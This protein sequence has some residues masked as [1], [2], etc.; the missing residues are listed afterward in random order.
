MFRSVL[1]DDEVHSV[2]GL[3]GDLVAYR[4]AGAGH[5]EFLAGNGF[6]CLR[7]VNC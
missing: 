1:E 6:S 3:L 7:H 4:A 5:L 2:A